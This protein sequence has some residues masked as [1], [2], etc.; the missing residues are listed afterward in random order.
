MP[1]QPTETHAI[2][3]ATAFTN[4]EISS[5]QRFDTGLCHFVYDV[6]AQGRRFVV[7]IAQA[8]NEHLLASGIGWSEILRQ[9]GVPLPEI[10]HADLTLSVFPF[11]YL[12]LERLDG[13][14][15]ELV[16]ARLSS[17]EKERLATD[18]VRLQEEVSTLPSGS[19]FG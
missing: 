3:I 11:P 7:R 17:K 13:S 18:V 8:G 14:D 9:R 4:S 10:L 5:I 1:P 16:Y 19:G 2:A 6:K 15:L 12:I